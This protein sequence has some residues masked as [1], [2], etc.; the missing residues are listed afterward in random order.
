MEQRTATLKPERL[1]MYNRNKLKLGL[2]G[3]NCSSG[4]AATKV[5]ERWSGSWEDNLRMAQLADA[6]GIDYL[7]PIGRWRGYGGATNFEGATYETITWACGL[8]QATQRIH[9]FGTV[10]APLLHPLFAAKQMVT[11]DHIGRGRFGL[12]IV[13]GWNV[14]EF[15]MFG[16]SPKEHDTR[17]E[18][19]EEWIRAICQMWESN[20]EFDFD[21]HFFQ[22][23]NVWAQPKPYG[24]TRP[25]VMNAAFSPAGREFAYRNCDFLFTLLR[26]HGQGA[27]AVAQTRAGAAKYGRKVGVFTPGYIVCR[28]TRKEAEDYHRYY[29][30]ENGDWDAVDGLVGTQFRSNSSAVTPELYRQLRIRY[31]GGHG[32]FPIIGSPDDVAS[33]L[34]QIS[35]D[36][37]DG[38]AFSFVN[39]V[40][41]LPFF[42]AEVL[43]RLERLGVRTASS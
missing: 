11:A 37:F 4:R 27:E 23:Q 22:L 30:E 15:A 26:D 36:G 39:Y 17:Y 13:C 24:G 25:I 42:A 7:L 5:P 20:E 2:F 29:A 1:S 38:Y 32:G 19:G 43:P 9:V 12:N 35:A 41:E 33:E 28:P 8:L 34:A 14:D 21:G 40:D 18:H 31:A 10:H 16:V 3:A 6:A